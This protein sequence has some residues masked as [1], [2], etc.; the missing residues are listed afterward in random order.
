MIIKKFMRKC[1]NIMLKVFSEA[2]TKY[3]LL[4]DEETLKKQL[5]DVTAYMEFIIALS[6]IL[7]EDEGYE[8]FISD[9]RTS[10]EQIIHNNKEFVTLDT[11]RKSE[12]YVSSVM[13]SLDDCS[14][15]ELERQKNIYAQMKLEELGQP[16]FIKK[17]EYA[18]VIKSNNFNLRKFKRIERKGS[19]KTIKSLENDKTFLY[20]INC[21]I[22]NYP[23]ALDREKINLVKKVVDNSSREK[24]DSVKDYLANEI[25]KVTTLNEISNLKKQKRK[26]KTL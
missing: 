9:K 18:D 14:K 16:L 7:K 19:E 8:F 22:N 3:N 12:E 13:Y 6:D 15:E 17:E 4:K 25:Y 24:L 10:I 23:E 2:K 11:V 1:G 21:I 20:L 26:I 5:C